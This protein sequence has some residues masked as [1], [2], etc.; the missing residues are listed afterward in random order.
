MNCYNSILDIQLLGLLAIGNPFKI[1]G[2]NPLKSIHPLM[3][4]SCQASTTML[5]LAVTE[6][7][8]LTSITSVTTD[9]ITQH[10]VSRATRHLLVESQDC[11]WC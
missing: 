6:Q 5:F 4:T 8:T 2:T 9:K 11:L 10:P 3:N 7:T 1:A